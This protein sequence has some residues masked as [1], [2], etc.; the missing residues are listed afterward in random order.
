MKKVMQLVML[1]FIPMMM[2][3]QTQFKFAY[4][5]SALADEALHACE[6]FPPFSS[7]VPTANDIVVC[8]KV[9]RNQQDNAVLKRISPTGN[10]IWSKEIQFPGNDEFVK[11][12]TITYQNSNDPFA[13]NFITEFWVLGT[14]I[15]PGQTSGRCAFISRFNSNGVMLQSFNIFNNGSNHLNNLSESGVDFEVVKVGNNINNWKIYIAGNRSVIPVGKSLDGFIVECQ[16]TGTINWHRLYQSFND[17]VAN[18]HDNDWILDM[19][20]DGST[21]VI[22]GRS[23]STSNNHETFCSKVN[24]S[25]GTIIN[26][27]RYNI[28]GN[29]GG[30]SIIKNGSGYLVL[31]QE[32][33]SLIRLNLNNNLSVSSNIVY[34]LAGT[35]NIISAGLSSGQSGRFI[36]F[37][38][39]SNANTDA[40][41]FE[42]N[43]SNN[44]LVWSK[45]YGEPSSLEK[46]N[47][48]LATSDGH[49]IAVG[50]KNMR[51]PL[52]TDFLVLKMNSAGSVNCCERNATQTTSTVNVGAGNR[53]FTVSYNKNTQTNTSLLV[54]CPEHYNLCG[55]LNPCFVLNPIY[56]EDEDI[57]T[58]VNCMD[59]RVQSYRWVLHK[60]NQNAPWTGICSTAYLQGPV[61][62]IN[63]KSMCNISVCQDYALSIDVF[64][65]CGGETQSATYVQEF[66]VAPKP[67]SMPLA[68]YTIPC[69]QTC[70]NVSIPLT[71]TP[72]LPVSPILLQQTVTWN[73]GYVGQTRTICKSPNNVVQNFTVTVQNEWGCSRTYP[74]QVIEDTCCLNPCFELPDTIC[75]LEPYVFTDLSCMPTNISSYRWVLHE[76][77]PPAPWTG[78]CSTG[79]LPGPVVP[80]DVTNMCP[81]IPGK[82][83]AL[84]I[85]VF[86]ECN[87]QVISKTIVREFYFQPSTY[88]YSFRPVQGNS[89]T[90]NLNYFGQNECNGNLLY[91][92]DYS[93][94]NIGSP[95][96]YYPPFNPIP[97][98]GEN[99]TMEYF[100]DNCCVQQVNF[101]PVWGKMQNA[102]S[103][104]PVNQIFEYSI[105]PSPASTV[106]SI[107]NSML[108]GTKKVLITDL[109]GKKVFETVFNEN[110]LNIDV[111]AWLNGLYFA[112][113]QDD[114]GVKTYKFMVLH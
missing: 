43:L 27:F 18:Q 52:P 19:I 24:M 59:K 70:I 45:N 49:Y 13:L 107:T 50:A 33:Q 93:S 86:K 58:N 74:I 88:T 20:A 110:T 12:K 65:E 105:Y 98:N 38:N 35:G 112:N 21:L 111:K 109:K 78:I 106:V 97:Y 73:D 1:F 102:S 17:V 84:S 83:Y 39:M 51:V 87:G 34:N 91:I 53:F 95:L 14:R 41:V 2:T 92:K 68:S 25:N 63:V 108:K 7:P 66:K 113:I 31:A 77:N 42:G 40:F 76:L 80:I 67:P 62:P 60:L 71:T 6:V 69:E 100:F 3:A 28:A 54:D 55:P 37:R 44:N 22:C 8:G 64:Y 61:Q 26:E 57:I 30:C 90:L 85:D 10:L 36:A 79:Y 82:S 46:I 56:C 101:Y 11:V 75:A 94:G 81:L 15:A 29:G 96:I 48:V 103:S 99:L 114:Q 5:E 9:N 23:F 16:W 4:G 47:F 104:E 72:C 32:N 89:P